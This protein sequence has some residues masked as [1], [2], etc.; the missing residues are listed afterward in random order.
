MQ[1]ILLRLWER[2]SGLFSS[3]SFMV[4]G[5]TFKSLIHLSLFYMWCEKGVQCDSVACNCP[6]FQK[7]FIEE[8]VFS[9][10]RFLPPLS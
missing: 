10:C 3:V 5:I 6:I 7:P 2:A 8:A 4:S 1:K 9:H